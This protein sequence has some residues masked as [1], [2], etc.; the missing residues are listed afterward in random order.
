MS[1]SPP[2]SVADLIL[3]EGY[4]V[5][6]RNLLPT[7]E[8]LAAELEVLKN[9]QCIYLGNFEVLTALYTGHK[10]YVDSRDVGIASHI[11]WEGRWEPWIEA[12]LVPHIKPGM[13]ALDIGANF[14][15]YTLLMAQAVGPKGHVF[16]FEANPSIAR[17]LIKSVHV[18]G[19]SPWTTVHQVALS[20]AVG[21]AEFQYDPQFSGGGSLGP[22][23]SDEHIKLTVPTARL[24]DLLPANTAV[25]IVKMDVEG[26]E[27]LVLTGGLSAL[28]GDRLCRVVTE[29]FPAAIAQHMNPIDF[30]GFF[31]VRGFKLQVIQPAGLV[32]ATAADII[33]GQHGD[34]QYLLF[35]RTV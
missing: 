33:S 6:L 29:F 13:V 32:D 3:D 10:I 7:V 14:G 8:K 17:K 26:A 21:E 24:D 2:E 12:T 28:G 11:M 19:L 30:L 15:Y 5:K 34:M 16:A 18:N 9:R 27:A 25:D 1:I 20:N 22:G 4:P 23:Y 31:T 35:T